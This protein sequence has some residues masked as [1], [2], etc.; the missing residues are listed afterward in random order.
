MTQLVDGHLD[1]PPDITHK[2]LQCVL[3]INLITDRMVVKF[4]EISVLMFLTFFGTLGLNV[5]S[6]EYK[7]IHFF[8]FLNVL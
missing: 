1:M 4:L 3:A 2:K 8:L 7:N 5:N 6:C